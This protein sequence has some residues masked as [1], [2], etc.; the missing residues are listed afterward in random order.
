MSRRIRTYRDVA[1]P[2]SEDI[3]AQVSEQR[4]RLERRLA[5]VGATI[6]VASGKGGVGKS[7][8]VANLAAALADRGLSVGAVD[9]D[10]NGP[11]LARMLGASGPLRVDE[12]GA[13]PADGVAGVRAISMDL[14]LEAD[15]PLEWRGS[16]EGV[17]VAREALE[18][19][20]LREFL[21]DVVWG[22]LD[23]LVLDLPPGTDALARTLGLIP[24]LDLLLLVTTPS[25]AARGVVARS[26]AAARRAEVGM[27]AL[28]A[29]MTEYRCPSC[30]ASEPLYP[31]A[32]VEPLAESSGLDVWAEIPFEPALASATDAG[33]PWVL[34]A[35]SAPAA[36]ALAALAERVVETT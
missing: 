33:R 36:R 2:A 7:A 14:L 30:G 34:E 19:G 20:A 4:E 23:A 9:G 18:T 17:G 21:A 32:A 10:L 29:N 15:A 3:V 31:D 5:D 22:P 16:E 13:H 24:D 35:P 11:A 26:V 12:E 27:V 1:D 28:V 8:V 25:S 6:A